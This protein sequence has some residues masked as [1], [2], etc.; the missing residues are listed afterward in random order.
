MKKIITCAGYHGTGSS[1]VSDLLKEFKGVKSFGEFEFRFLQDPNGVGDLEDKLIY[2]NCRLNSDRAIYD[3]KKFIQETGTARGMKFWKENTYEKVFHNKFLKIT[4]EYIDDLV[5]L[6]WDG[7]WHDVYLRKDYRKFKY[8][9]WYKIILRKLKIIKNVKPKTTKIFF[10]YPIE[11]F[12]DKTKKYLNKLILAT[13][14]KEDILVFDQLLPICNQ[15]K[16]LKYFEDIKVI[17]FDR[18]PRD[19][20]VL[21][22]L[23]WK[24]MVVPTK[25]VDVFI[26]HF[27]LIRK[28]KKFEINDNIRVK[29]VQFEDF[30]YNYDEAVKELLEFLNINKENHIKKKQFFNPEVSINNTQVFRAHPELKDDIRK[31]EIELS[32]YCYKFPYKKI[33]NEKEKVF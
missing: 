30:I 29:N 33:I 16:Y 1:V 9:L 28:H 10:S 19:L 2:N 32:D 12:V 13:E 18:D 26:K 4:N 11:N 6:S 8:I 14:A 23:Y 31:I 24:E 15:N 3:F 17:N 5:D 25:N 7:M 22:K 27:L 20:Y 21:N